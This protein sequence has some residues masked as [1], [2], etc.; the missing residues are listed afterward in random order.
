MKWKRSLAV[1]I[2]I[3]GLVLSEQVIRACA[4][5]D[6]YDTYPQF[7]G[8]TVSEK[9]A[10]APF[11]FIE[12]DLYYSDDLWNEGRVVTGSDKVNKAMILQEW[13]DMLNNG[14]TFSDIEAVLYDADH[15][16]LISAIES[17]DYAVAG[18]AAAPFFKYLQEK[19]NRAVRDYLLYA[20]KCEINALG[21]A[22]YWNN[23]EVPRSVADN[24]TLMQEGVSAFKKEK[25]DLLKMKYAFQAMRM[26]FYSGQYDV[27]LQQFDDLLKG[28]SDNSVAYTRI[29]GFKAGAHYRRGEKPE[30]AYYYSRMFDNS[31]A[32]KYDAM[33]SFEWARKQYD[34]ETY[35][36]K[37]DHIDDILGLCK[38][39][40]ERAVVL[41]MKALRS[42]PEFALKDIKEAYSLDPK[43][44][45]IDV[46]MNREINKLESNYFRDLV[47][48]QNALP[49][50]SRHWYYNIRNQDHGQNEEQARKHA[51][52]RNYVQQ[53]NDFA[54]QLIAD[55]ETG[56]PA[57]WHLTKAYLA[58][59]QDSATAMKKELD[60]AQQAGMKPSEKS[61]HKVIGLLHVLYSSKKI[62]PE[63]EAAILPKLKDLDAL[64]VKDRKSAQQFRDVMTHLVAGKYFQQG[65]TIKAVY[66]MGHASSWDEKRQQFNADP[67]FQDMQGEVL[68]R[69]S[70]PKLKEVQV[71]RGSRNKTAF[72]N[73]LVSNT[74]YTP[75]VLQEL[76]GTK[77]IREYDFRAA[78]K[79]FEQSELASM[80]FANPFM[81]QINDYIELYPQDTARTYSKLSFSK[82][83]A[84]LQD[85]IAKDPGDAGALYGYAVALYNIS[86]Y[87]KVANMTLY[88]RISTD[89]NGYFRDASDAKMPRFL[90][91][92]YRVYSAEQYFNKA[93]AAAKDPELKAK[94][95]WGAAKCWT[96]RSP[97]STEHRSYYYD[98]AYYQNALQNPYFRKLTEL[99]QT[100]FVRTVKGTCDHYSDH[101]K[102]KG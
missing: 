89:V 25:N 58:C 66:A 41:V 75:A 13:S 99:S 72:E 37:R 2:S 35:L 78:I 93:A 50:L 84:E 16:Q 32:Y 9:P 31:D 42:Y 67:D 51:T 77:Y 61:L 96:K 4:D 40:H 70:I 30:A 83:M 23:S 88:N 86:Y 62:T 82:R 55:K 39:D 56:T 65:D 91:E 22:A 87:G 98:K 38:T 68:N 53:L 11:R 64:A 73:W 100:A 81:P 90:Q 17:P 80:Q 8:N 94:A 24:A 10:Y 60:R 33:V 47:Y 46:L 3:L 44:G 18:L 20:K 95:L 71:F 6:H 26:A 36:L 79:I 15:H 34:K 59:M 92:Y 101:L 5:Y 45:G 57:L 49:D 14:F 74:Y 21:D 76:E 102:R 12:G 28:W 97:S 27:V 1:S 29:L 52:A 43:V 69:M 54:D 19:R 85:I 63:I 7:F 48:A